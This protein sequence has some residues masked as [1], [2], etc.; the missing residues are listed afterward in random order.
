GVVRGG[1]R[2]GPIVAG[3]PVQS[4]PRLHEELIKMTEH[5]TRD[6]VA[7]DVPT[8][9]MNPEGLPAHADAGRAGAAVDALRDVFSLESLPTLVEMVEY[10]RQRRMMFIAFTIDEITRTGH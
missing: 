8:H 1:R 2:A 3:D 6:L 10:Y 4:S 5:N 7:I 9:V